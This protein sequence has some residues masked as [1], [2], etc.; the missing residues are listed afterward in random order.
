[1]SVAVQAME[2]AVGPTALDEE[3]NDDVEDSLPVNGDSE[4]I[5]RPGPHDVLL[6]RGGGTNN[7]V[8]NVRFRQLVNEHKIR[9]LE[10]NKVDKPKVA[11]EVVKLWRSLDPPGRFL[12][13]LDETRRGPGSIQDENIVWVEC[14]DKKAR[15]KTSQCLRERTAEVL[16]HLNNLRQ[17]QDHMTEHGVSLVEQ[18]MRMGA[19]PEMEAA[20]MGTGA[21]SQFLPS[22]MPSNNMSSL[23]RGS[24]PVTSMSSSAEFGAQP[25]GRSQDRRT[26]APTVNRLQGQP[27]S[28][29]GLDMNQLYA[30]QQQVLREAYTAIEKNGDG[31]TKGMSSMQ[32]GGMMAPPLTNMDS[33]MHM[34]NSQALQNR[35]M[36]QQQQ[37]MNNG[38]SPGMGQMNNSNA[39]QQLVQQQQMLMQ[40]QQRLAAQQQFLMAQERMIAERQAQQVMSG[41]FMSQMSPQQR[42]QMQ[43]TSANMSMSNMGIQPPPFDTTSGNLGDFEPFPYQGPAAAVPDKAGS[44]GMTLNHSPEHMDPEKTGI[45]AK[46]LKD[47]P[48]SSMKAEK[49]KPKAVEKETKPR[50]QPKKSTKAA[51]LAADLSPI[52]DT[53]EAQVSGSDPTM[54]NYI[55]TLE[56]YV[57]NQQA[58]APTLDIDDDETIEP[59][60]FKGIDTTAWL[61]DALND[62]TEIS[63]RGKRQLNRANSKKS[64]MSM[65]TSSEQ[66]SLAFSDMEQSLDQLSKESQPQQRKQAVRSMSIA[67]AQSLLSELTDFDELDTL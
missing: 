42:L 57:S 61:Q 4:G 65:G 41:Q 40:Q 1:M 66:M 63:L 34:Q 18:Q 54:R 12:Q 23:R 3:E 59:E 62:D 22:Q 56:T 21:M 46:N 33:P 11:R 55:K 38:L 5:R 31:D 49:G 47:P 32:R 37:M 50:E 36:A 28:P 2:K 64:M 8:G 52:A 9:Y 15:E 26:S 17:R 43:D 13:R 39:Q 10:C 29:T 45:P 51:L 6:G 53:K 67:S 48:K 27:L 35:L 16:P 25:G 19:L 58:Q 7:H 24:L 60:D 30:R 44:A 14:G 20:S